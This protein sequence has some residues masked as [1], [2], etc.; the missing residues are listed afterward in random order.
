MSEECR[1][2]GET[3]RPGLK[4]HHEISNTGIGQLDLVAE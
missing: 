4:K 2:G 1:A 3:V